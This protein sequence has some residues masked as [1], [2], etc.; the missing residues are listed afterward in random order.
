MASSRAE[1]SGNGRSSMTPTCPLLSEQ[2]SSMSKPDE[3]MSLLQEATLE[4]C[5][6][7]QPLGPHQLDYEGLGLR[8]GDEI[9]DIPSSDESIK[10]ILR[11]GKLVTIKI[12][13]R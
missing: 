5:V 8:D 4:D 9:V 6:V 10:Y 13:A 11:N 1:R 2:V 12:P 3:S 7:N